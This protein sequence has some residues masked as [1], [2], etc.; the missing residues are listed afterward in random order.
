VRVDEAEPPALSLRGL[1]EN[2]AVTP[3]GLPDTERETEELNPFSDLTD[4]EELPEDPCAIVS[5]VGDVAKLKSGCGTVSVR[6][7]L[8]LSTP[9]VPVTFSM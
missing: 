7:A 2:I 5:E 3:A 6:V 1:A 8:C 4:M 9:L